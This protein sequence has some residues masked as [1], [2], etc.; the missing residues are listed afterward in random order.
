[1]NIWVILSIVWLV[2]L[3]IAHVVAMIKSEIYREVAGAAITVV[4]GALVTMFALVNI[5]NYFIVRAIV[6]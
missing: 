2:G 3:L 4:L 1:M 6:P 5:L